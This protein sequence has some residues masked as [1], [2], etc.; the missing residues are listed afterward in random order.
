MS[1]FLKASMTRT[2]LLLI[3][4]IFASGHRPLDQQNRYMEEEFSFPVLDGELVLAGTLTIPDKF[5]K[6]GKVAILVSPPLPISRDYSGLFK[7]LAEKLSQQG[8]T[9]LRYD[10][11][12]YL[13]SSWAEDEKATM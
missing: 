3:V 7:N 13:D 9:V 4:C 10:N 11:R 12:A 5:T 6:D 8:I 2:I 1:D